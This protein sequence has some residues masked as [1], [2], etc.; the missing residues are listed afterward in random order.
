MNLVPDS[1]FQLGPDLL[2]QQ[3]SHDEKI[4][5]FQNDTLK[6]GDNGYLTSP[7]YPSD[8]P[9]KSQ[10]IWWLKVSRPTSC[11]PDLPTNSE[12]RSSII[13]LTNH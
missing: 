6:P 2:A 12:F 10:C 1:E 3:R 5:G 4:C 11:S 9:P 7:N 8:Y 13:C